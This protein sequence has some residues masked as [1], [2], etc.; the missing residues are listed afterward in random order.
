MAIAVGGQKEWSKIRRQSFLD[1]A[2]E[3]GLGK[4]MIRREYDRMW[5]NF[6]SALQKA[7][8]ELNHQG[9]SDSAE[10]RDSILRAVNRVDG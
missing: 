3:M 1:S 4:N 2:D 6:P 7:A 9:F 5:K 10:M 8:E